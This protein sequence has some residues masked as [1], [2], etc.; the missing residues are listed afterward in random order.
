MRLVPTI[1]S[2]TACCLALAVSSA[3]QAQSQPIAD[4]T[5]TATA[6]A[7][8]APD[9]APQQKGD[10]PSGSANQTDKPTDKAKQKSGEAAGAISAT[11]KDADKSPGGPPT[12][13]GE[14]AASSPFSF[15]AAFTLDLLENLSG[16]RSTGFGKADLLKLSASYEG[17]ASGHDGLNGLISVEHS[18]G[19]SFTIRKLG[20][21]QNV[22]AAEA[23][24]A[25]LRLYEAWLQQAFLG[26][27]A[28]VKVGLIDLN[29]TFDV[30]QTAALFLNASHGIGPDF[31]DTGLNGPS[32]Y[33]TT[34]FGVTS[35]YRPNDAW[36]AQVGVFNGLAGDP[37]HRSDFVAVKL[38]GV[39][40]VG[41][42]ERRFGDVARIELGAFSYTARFPSL[43]RFNAD[44]TARSVSGNAGIY[45]LVEGKLI[46]SGDQGGGLSG[47]VRVG[48]SNGDIN[49]VSNY[50]GAGLVYA[51]PIPGRDKDEVGIALARAGLGEG[52]RVAGQAAGRRIGQAETV[53]EATYRYSLNDTLSL[54]PDL[55]YVIR[56]HGDSELGNAL[57]F[58]LRLA[59][60]ISN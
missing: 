52:S 19:S 8:P 27:A 49:P 48:V 56:P 21:L 22:T 32:I 13:G 12:S 9:P 6:P 43:D 58:G 28:G 2:T 30:Q 23:E 15:S 33:P 25:S 18:F 40:L 16:G 59:L 20:G 37:T 51:G 34:A 26:D 36:T 54:Q 17:S 47:W 53:F 10:K 38:D 39:L 44:G 45:G 4:P 3:A 57:V 1:L 46:S 60:T 14:S 41:Q 7:A 24:P 55:Q 29:T 50:L 11:G 35:F 31:G 42:I 5:K